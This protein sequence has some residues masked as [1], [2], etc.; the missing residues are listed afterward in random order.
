MAK[1]R[2]LRGCVQKVTRGAPV[3]TAWLVSAVVT[4]LYAGGSVVLSEIA[5]QLA[6]D[7]QRGFWALLMRL[8]RNLKSTTVH[9]DV[10]LTRYLDWAGSWT[11]RGFDVICVDSSEIVKRYG[12]VMP[13]FC[14]VRDASESK[15]GECRLENGWWTTEIVATPADHQ[16]IPLRRRLWSSAEPGHQS[17]NRETCDTILDVLP[18]VDPRALWVFDRGFESNRLIDWLDARGMRWL[19]RQRGDPHV[20]LPMLAEKFPTEM[21]GAALS[22]PHTARP[23][24]SRKNK[25]VRIELAF[26]SCTVQRTSRGDYLTLI[27]AKL[28]RSKR[29]ML[30]LSNVRGRREVDARRLVE[31]YLRRWAVEDEIRAAKQLLDLENVRLLTWTS[32]QR[33]VELSVLPTGLLAL[34]VAEHPRSARWL[35]KQAPIVDPVPPYLAYRLVPAVR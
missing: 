8:S 15:R 14:K 33:M 17:Q 19:I 29:P 2:W 21:L 20:W 25:L 26:G 30:L 13:F 27:A 9:I 7:T 5:R 34:H 31:A 11:G 22:T 4:G 6:S 16:V 24:V 23:L 18:F 32:L 3:R 28:P 10:A 1:L 35:A 12:R